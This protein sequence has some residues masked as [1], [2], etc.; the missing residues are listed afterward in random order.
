MDTSSIF[1]NGIRFLFSLTEIKTYIAHLL[2][3]CQE[4]LGL[5]SILFRVGNALLSLLKIRR[6]DRHSKK[7]RTQRVYLLTT[8]NVCMGGGVVFSRTSSL[9][10]GQCAVGGKLVFLSL[11]F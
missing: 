5:F 9:T 10:A 2:K 6:S 8:A 1:R 11:G 7:E 4:C 3:V